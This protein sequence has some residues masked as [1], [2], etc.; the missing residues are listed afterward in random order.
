V[1][2]HI[3]IEGYQLQKEKVRTHQS[4]QIEKETK[5]LIAYLNSLISTFSL[6]FVCVH[7]YFGQ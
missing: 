2:R 7:E 3:A 5:G 1:L 4:T 6:L